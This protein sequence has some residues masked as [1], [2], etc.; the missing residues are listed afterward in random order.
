M[1]PIPHDPE[2]DI[3]PSFHSPQLQTLIQ[4]PATPRPAM[5][6]MARSGTF[7]LFLRDLS[8]SRSGQQRS[9]GIRLNATAE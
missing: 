6:E 5:A 4:I 1:S 3:Q 9:I 2:G 7:L 8:N